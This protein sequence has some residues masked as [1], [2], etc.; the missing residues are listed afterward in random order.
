M[1]AQE[2]EQMVATANRRWA[3][4]PDG[5]LQ[6]AI[7]S[8]GRWARQIVGRRGSVLYG[9]DAP[10]GTAAA[11]IPGGLGGWFYHQVESGRRSLIDLGVHRL[12]LA[13]WHD[14]LSDPVAVS[15]AAY[16]E[17]GK[18]LATRQGKGGTTVEDMAA[19]FIRFC[20][21]RHPRPG[22]ILGNQHGQ[23]RG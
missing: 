12:D 18:E 23:A 15:G 17:L 13:L 11:A 8:R 22:S 5:P 14:G 16:S 21:R 19:G 2:A 6:H 10:D 20:Q 9:S 3:G 1:N 7:G 4:S